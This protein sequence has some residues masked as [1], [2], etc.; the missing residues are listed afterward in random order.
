[1]YKY[2]RRSL[3]RYKTRTSEKWMGELTDFM[4]P[5]PSW[6]A[7]NCAATQEL[8]SVLWNPKPHHLVHKNPP[9]VPI[10]SQIDPVHTTPSYL[11]KIHFNSFTHL[12][13][14]LPSSLF[15][16]SLPTNIIYAS[17][18]DGWTIRNLHYSVFSSE[19]GKLSH[20]S[21]CDTTRV[22]GFN[23]QRYKLFFYSLLRPERSCTHPAYLMIKAELFPQ[24]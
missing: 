8:P 4:G 6:E 11:S 9:L 23:Y 21:N 5:S 10:L 2:R 17:C 16:S 13:L 20:C 1:M 15:P 18:M 22:S 7:V 14:G 12:R 3:R 24:G 19:S